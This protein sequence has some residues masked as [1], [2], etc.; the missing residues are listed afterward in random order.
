LTELYLKNDIALKSET[1]IHIIFVDT[2][3]ICFY[4]EK[5]VFLAYFFLFQN[6][7]LE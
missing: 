1:W 6:T 4:T 5:K 2:F 3:T 7:L